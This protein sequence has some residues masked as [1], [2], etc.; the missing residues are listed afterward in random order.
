MEKTPDRIALVMGLGRSGTT[1]LAKLIDTAPEVLYR[2][3]PDAVLPTDLP[4]FCSPGQFELLLPK[5]RDY[6]QAMADCRHFRSVGTLPV[7]KKSFRSGPANLAFKAMLLSAKAA[8]RLKLPTTRILPDLI[9]AEHSGLLRLIKSVSALG[10]A[11]LYGEAVS[12]L[13]SI[14]IVRHPC[15][16][17]ASLFQGFEKGLMR[18]KPQIKAL[19]SC[20]E[21]VSYP[22][23][24]DDMKRASFEEQIAYRWMVTNDKAAK[25]MAGSSRYLRIGYEELCTEVEA[26]SRRIFDHLGLPLGPQTQHFIDEVSSTPADGAKAA[27][28]FDVKRSITSGLDKWKTELD[29]DTIERIREVVSHSPLGRAYFEEH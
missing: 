15:A 4:S 5:A 10:R 14:H 29:A 2:H 3:E 17:Y 24:L 6:V 28:Y 19:F 27:G 25:D 7:F 11:H 1:F 21:S 18:A 12:H 16:V 20:P 26:V 8:R 23:T 9:S 22:F 13:R